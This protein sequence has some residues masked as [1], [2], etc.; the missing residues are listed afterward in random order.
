MSLSQK[1]ILFFCYFLYVWDIFQKINAWSFLRILT[2]SQIE[3]EN[4]SALM[5]QAA[6]RGHLARDQVGSNL[7]FL[8]ADIN[9]TWRR[10]QVASR[11][12]PKHHD[13]ALNV[14]RVYREY[15]LWLNL[16]EF[17]WI[18]IELNAVNDIQLVWPQ[19]VHKGEGWQS[20]L[21]RNM[22]KGFWTWSG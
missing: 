15:K 16:K 20:K 4:F 14:Q 8:V 12:T 6:Y 9:K 5:I 21:D 18:W 13:A 3:S 1:K 2:I 10:H 17:E 11:N 19:E 22:K 7:F